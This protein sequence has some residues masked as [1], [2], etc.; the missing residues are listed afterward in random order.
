MQINI[1]DFWSQNFFHRVDFRNI[2]DILV[3]GDVIIEK[4]I[5]FPYEEIEKPGDKSSVD[6]DGKKSKQT[7]N[8]SEEDEEGGRTGS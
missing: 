4:L 5:D 1:N 8:S 3:T 7:K 2:G 6:K